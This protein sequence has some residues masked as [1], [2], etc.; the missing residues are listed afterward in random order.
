METNN[1]LNLTNYT[2][3]ELEALRDAINEEQLRR[4]LED[5]P[6]QVGDCFIDVWGDNYFICRIDTINSLNIGV[7][8]IYNRYN[9]INCG[10]T[11]YRH[12]QFIKEW[13]NRI[14]SKIFDVYVDVTATISRLK[15]EF[16]N[17]IN[18]YS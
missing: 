11:E 2:E 17:K 12:E 6:Y 9:D 8:V 14:D 15:Q 4:K 18:E 16:I 1:M 10:Q 3:Q 7:T 5:F 13:H